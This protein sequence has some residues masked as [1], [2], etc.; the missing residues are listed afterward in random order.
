MDGRRYI[1]YH[2]AYSAI[3]LGH[4]YEPVDE[5]VVAALRDGILFG[6]G[7]TEAECELAKKIVQHVPSIDQVLLCNSGSEATYHAIRLA[8]GVTGRSKLIKFQGCYH[9]FHDSVLR[10]VLSKPDMIGQRDPGSA[11]MLDAAIDNTLVCRYNDLADVKRTLAANEGQVAAILVEPI[12]HNSPTIMPKADFLEGLRR[13]A[14]RNGAL[15]IFDEVITGFRHGLGGYQAICGVL[16]DLTTLGKA[17]AN[18]FP[19]AAVGGRQQYMERFQTFPGGI[20]HFAGT[21]NGNRVSA[22]AAL[23]TIA[24]LEHED[25]HGHIFRLGERMRAGLREIV[26]RTSAPALVSGFGSV[27]ALLFMKGPLESYDDVVRNDSEKQVRY[28]QELIRRGIFEMPENVGRNCVSFSHTE[29]DI[30][31]TLDIAE[32]ALRAVL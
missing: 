12:A 8:R 4:A 17:L 19:V 26:E 31:A 2:G 22:V 3:L 5:K 13:L 32:A 14:D 25:V 20:V 23:S 21:N 27:F 6:V 11:G 29:A 15:L 24:V 7:V 18:G 16:P 28:R 9:G 1:D 30:D 10:N